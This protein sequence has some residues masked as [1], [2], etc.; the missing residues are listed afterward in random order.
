MHGRRKEIILADGQLG[1]P[2]AQ[3]AQE[4]PMVPCSMAIEAVRSTVPLEAMDKLCTSF[5]RSARRWEFI[6]YPSIVAFVAMMGGAF[7]FIYTVTHELRD[8]ALQIQPQLG[9]NII[10]VAE[11]VTQL[12]DSL[13]QMNRNIDT[14]RARIETMSTDIGSMNTQMA[15]MKNIET[16]STQMA[17]MNSTMYRLNAQADAMRWN[18]QTM[19]H[20][21]SKPMSMFNSFMPW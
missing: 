16:M 6:V 10:K 18:M 15:Y 8:L 12:T 2:Q 14:M 13:N 11:S 7:F 20:S 4:G 19:N 1:P 3:A 17:Q 5:Q 21:I 9:A